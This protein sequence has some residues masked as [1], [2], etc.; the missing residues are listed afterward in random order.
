MFGPGSNCKGREN[1]EQHTDSRMPVYCQRHHLYD[2]SPAQGGSPEIITGPVQPQ[3][4]LPKD[5]HADPD[6]CSHH[7][8]SEDGVRDCPEPEIPFRF[9]EEECDHKGIEER[10][11]PPRPHHEQRYPSLGKHPSMGPDTMC[12]HRTDDLSEIVD[13][14]LICPTEG[15]V[16]VVSNQRRKCSQQTGKTENHS[17]ERSAAK[18]IL[19]F[20]FLSSHH[21]NKLLFSFQ[22]SILP[23]R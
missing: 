22:V 6:Q 17:E 2:Q 23:S 14:R 7:C 10:E 19:F 12:L 9:P 8:R 3:K 11:H 20:Q 5:R 4:N 18:A 15:I 16:E 1:E 21:G 13:P